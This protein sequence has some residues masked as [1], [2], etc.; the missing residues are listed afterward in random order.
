MSSRHDHGTA[1]P[2]GTTHVDEQT[3]GLHY[4]GTLTYARSDAIDRHLQVCASCTEKAEDIVEIVAVLAL[5]VEDNEDTRP[6]V[7]FPAPALRRPQAAQR[8]GHRPVSSAGPRSSR[9]ATYRPSRGPRRRSR[10]PQ[11]V[12]ASLLL[13]LALFFAGLGLTA[14]ITGG[15][16]SRGSLGE[17]VAGE[18][19]DTESG[20]S[21]SV[22]VTDTDTDLSVRLTVDG[23]QSGTR[24]TLY[25]VA[26][27]GRAREV[28]RWT[29]REGV[30]DITANLGTVNLDEL[31]F[32]T[33]KAQSGDTAVSVHLPGRP[34][35]ATTSGPR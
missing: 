27:D 21:A 23:L 3:L 2:A 16:T 4:L 22:F 33:I 35:T 32:F 17:T 26:V 14:I 19:V 13:A 18:G 25:S 15:N 28:T 11:V 24:Y 8:L 1:E 34:A 29:G 12:S 5:T 20:A 30:H 10:T 9:G 6:P 7:D 31:S